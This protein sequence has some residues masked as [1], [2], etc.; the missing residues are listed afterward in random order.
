[1]RGIMM[2]LKRYFIQS[3]FTNTKS[4]ITSTITKM[5]FSIFSVF[6]FETSDNIFRFFEKTSK[7]N[8][9]NQCKRPHILN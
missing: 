6:F 8:V 4:T 1:M 5:L 7:S 2:L 9:Y 3:G